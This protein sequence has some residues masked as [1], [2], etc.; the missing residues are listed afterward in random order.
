MRH[1]TAF[2]IDDLGINDF[3]IDVRI[4]DLLIKSSFIVHHDLSSVHRRI[5]VYSILEVDDLCLA[6]GGARSSGS[7]AEAVA[8]Q[9]FGLVEG[10]NRP[11]R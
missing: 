6:T 10:R 5:Y 3:R 11:G 8:A 4:D 2:Y 1:R 9:S 7:D